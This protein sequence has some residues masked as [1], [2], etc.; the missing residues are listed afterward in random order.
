MVIEFIKAPHCLFQVERHERVFNDTAT[1]KVNLGYIARR[2]DGSI[3]FSGYSID[4]LEQILTK[5][6]DFQG[7]MSVRNSHTETSGSKFGE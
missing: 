1:S 6:K 3:H 2:K 7:G 4:E 5:M